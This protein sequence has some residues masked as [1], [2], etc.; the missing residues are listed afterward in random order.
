[1]AAGRYDGYWEREL[2]IWDVAAGSLIAQEAGA[3][4]EGIREGQDPLE[5][6]SLI[7]GNN[8]IFD[9]FARIIRSI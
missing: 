1:M 3:L 4:L 7:C 2:K 6:G 5:S 9:P 8:A